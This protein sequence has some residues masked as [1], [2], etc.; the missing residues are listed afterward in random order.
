MKDL[1]DI[2][3]YP[4]GAGSPLVLAQS[5]IKTKTASIVKELLKA[6]AWLSARP[7]PTSSPSAQRAERDFGSPDHPAAPER[8]TGGSSRGSMAAV[9]GRLADIAV[10]SDTGGSVVRRA[11]ELW[12]P[13]RH[14][15]EPWPALLKR[16]RAA[17]GKPGHPPGWFARDGETFARVANVLFGPDKAE[18]PE[19]PA[20]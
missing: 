18:L 20:C 1:F 13:L 6:G 16:A 10:G 11:C 12:R 3:G 2:K 15:P 4:T 5:G 19:A 9:A 17:G 7:I 8:I 14:P